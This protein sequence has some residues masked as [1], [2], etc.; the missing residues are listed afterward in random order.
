MQKDYPLQ[1]LNTLQ[2][3]CTAKLLTEISNTYQ[4]LKLLETPERRENK[5]HIL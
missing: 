4:L 5:H 2:I 1:S 3:N